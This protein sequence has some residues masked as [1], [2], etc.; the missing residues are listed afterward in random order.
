MTR[1]LGREPRTNPGVILG[2]LSYMSPEQARGLKV[3]ARSDLFSLGVVL[4]EMVAGRAPF[5]ANTSGDMI[6][7]IL[8]REPPPL[9]RFAPQTPDDLLWIVAKALAKEREARYQSAKDLLD[10]LKRAQRRLEFATSQ[11]DDTG[12]LPGLATNPLP[13]ESDKL[14]RESGSGRM[15]SGAQRALNSSGSQPL[16]SLAVLPLADHSASHSQD[17]NAVYLCEGIPESLILNLSRLAQLRVMAWSTVARFQKAQGQQLD[18]LAIGRELGVRAVLAG[19]LYQ[20]GD[21]LVI[22]IELV[23]TADGAQ[24]WGEQYQRKLADLLTLEEEISR[25]ICEKLRLRLDSEERKR[26]AKRYT[27]NHEAYQAYLRGRHYWK[28][29][30]AQ[31]LRKGIESFQ[32][33]I[34]LDENYALAYT[35]LSDCYALVSIYGAAPPRAIMPKARAAALKALELDDS[36]AEAHTSLA[37]TQV[38]FDWDWAGAER[39]FQRAFELNPNY[40]VAWHWYGSV[41]LSA[42]GRHD[43]ALEAEQRALALE[44]FTLIYNLHPGFICY[45]AGRYDE[46]IGY[47]RHTLELDEQFVLAHFYLGLAYAQKGEHAAAIASL[48]RALELAGGRGAL[49]QAALAYAYA[50]AGERAEAQGILQQLRSFPL[51]RDVSPFYL[52]L[53]YAGLGEREAALKALQDA[54]AEKFSWLVWLKS[55]P[56]FASIR[57]DAR[58]QALI[59]EMS[60]R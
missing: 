57:D 58:Y 31:A 23:D 13:S 9:R 25:E 30:T 5:Q 1:E 14:A 20:F 54:V 37:V 15:P 27:E 34:A 46:A 38:W 32:Q 42:R 18:A 24:L 26:L 36:L 11:G 55:E 45:Q 40:S 35:G 7:Q 6:V 22:K 51:N 49:I 52:A 56:M 39:A 21:N 53:I 28:Q 4:Y 44:P 12:Q 41:L 29:R 3:D 47:Y 10:D 43:E 17:A 60:L 16:D 19:R 48:K 33:A 59:D 8:D 2:T 50:R